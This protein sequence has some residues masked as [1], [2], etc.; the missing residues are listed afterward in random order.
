MYDGGSMYDG[1]AAYGT[2]VSQ[3]VAS[4]V[5]SD[6]VATPSLDS[7]LPAASIPA[8][9]EGSIVVPNGEGASNERSPLVDPSAFVIRGN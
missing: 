3:P 2:P 1:G 4:P 9:T 8:A 5:I 6:P 7:T